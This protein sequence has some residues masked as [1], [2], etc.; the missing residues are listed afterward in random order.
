MFLIGQ[1]VTF[2]LFIRTR[3]LCDT[4]PSG[5]FYSMVLV[6]KIMYDGG[7]TSA[8]T[9]PYVRK[10]GHRISEIFGLFRRVVFFLRILHMRNI[11]MR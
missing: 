10:V 3:A 1:L 9:I 7:S 2:A 6:V 5:R 8:S 11:G 4:S